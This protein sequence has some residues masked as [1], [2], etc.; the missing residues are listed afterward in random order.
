MPGRGRGE[1]VLKNNLCYR[2]N[3][4]PAWTTQQ[5]PVLKSTRDLSEGSVVKSTSWS[6]RGPEFSPSTQHGQPSAGDLTPSSASTDTQH[7]PHNKIRSYTIT[8]KNL[9]T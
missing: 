9:E 1:A 5:D 3:P 6:C 2:V 7:M 8:I 4:R